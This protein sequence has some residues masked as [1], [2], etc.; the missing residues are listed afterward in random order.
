MNMLKI[1]YCSGQRA[2]PIKNKVGEIQKMNQTQFGW[3][4]EIGEEKDPDKKNN[5]QKDYDVFLSNLEAQVQNVK[6]LNPCDK[7]TFWKFVE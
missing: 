6:N 1:E 4:E 7:C 2:C 5:L 3:L